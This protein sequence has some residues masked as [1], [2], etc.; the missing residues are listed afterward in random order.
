MELSQQ[1]HSPHEACE[2]QVSVQ[3]SKTCDNWL[4]VAVDIS[5]ALFVALQ[6][7][8]V[9]YFMKLLNIV[10]SYGV[11][12]IACSLTL[13]VLVCSVASCDVKSLQ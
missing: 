12:L 4:F 5:T 8:S 10:V 13:G 9:M 3:R 7:Y 11:H 1:I 6:A 2:E